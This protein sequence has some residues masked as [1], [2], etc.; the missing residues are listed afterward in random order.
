MGAEIFGQP[1]IVRLDQSTLGLQIQ[2]ILQGASADP[3]YP[4]RQAI[5]QLCPP[6]LRTR[7]EESSVDASDFLGSP[8][9]GLLNVRP[10][11]ADADPIVHGVEVA[12]RVMGIADL[13]QTAFP[14][15]SP[16]WVQTLDTC[17]RQVLSAVALTQPVP[18]TM[19]G[20]RPIAKVRGSVARAM[21]YPPPECRQIASDTLDSL[22]D[23][24]NLPPLLR[25]VFPSDFTGM[26]D[27]DIR[28]SHPISREALIQQ[29]AQAGVIIGGA[30]GNKTLLTMGDGTPAYLTS[31]NLLHKGVHRLHLQ[32]A[33]GKPFSF[34]LAT[35]SADSREQSADFRIGPHQPSKRGISLD[36]V[37]RRNDSNANLSDVGVTVVDPVELI[38][39]LTLSS[40]PEM[41]RHPTYTS[42]E[43]GILALMS[44]LRLELFTPTDPF[45]RE[46]SG[47]SF[48]PDSIQTALNHVIRDWYSSVHRH[49]F[50]PTRVD[51][52]RRNEIVREA[53]VS[54]CADKQSTITYMRRCGLDYMLH[55][56]RELRDIESMSQQDFNRAV[57]TRPDFAH[58]CALMFDL[59]R[60]WLP[61][62]HEKPATY[63]AGM[64]PQSRGRTLQRV[65]AFIGSH[66]LGADTPGNFLDVL[67]KPHYVTYFH[68]PETGWTTEAPDHHEVMS[69]MLCL[70]SVPETT[71]LDRI[72]TINPSVWGQQGMVTFYQHI[73]DLPPFV[74]E[75]LD[76]RYHNFP[77]TQLADMLQAILLTGHDPWYPVRV[78]ENGLPEEQGIVGFPPVLIQSAYSKERGHITQMTAPLMLHPSKALYL[79]K[80][81]LRSGRFGSQL[82]NGR[83]RT[84]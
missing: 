4:V 31:T 84:N 12:P 15:E 20:Y 8:A 26:Y 68:L 25:E 72:A 35:E 21:Y 47:G 79:V 44:N 29:L 82:Q 55:C 6:E 43:Q 3:E 75:L 34:D 27:M 16:D 78:G 66:T 50:P 53:L 37:A 73:V 36:I 59:H 51:P 70:L 1:C 32:P 19:G 33:Q 62:P 28:Y 61:P 42:L 76:Q 45:I 7:L 64:L 54:L 49:D 80:N 14:A 38:N 30:D 56:V 39:Y 67:R 17:A 65:E 9:W 18:I 63:H 22:R 2:N 58:S 46:L 11:F 83:Q 24:P 69:A 74:E 71:A 13:I 77:G 5:V 10:P 41:I 23:M 60:A 57:A 48:D 81:S 40:V 52:F